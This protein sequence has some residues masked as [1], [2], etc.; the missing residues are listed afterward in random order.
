M[1][2]YRLLVLWF[3][4]LLLVSVA[5]IEALNAKE[6]RLKMHQVFTLLSSRSSKQREIESR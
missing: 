1:C 6:K 4:L 3:G 5:L 2:A